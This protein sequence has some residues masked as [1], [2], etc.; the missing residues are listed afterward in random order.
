MALN[1]R[2]DS[3]DTLCTYKCLKY[4]HVGTTTFMHILSHMCLSFLFRLSGFPGLAQPNST[5][6]DNIGSKHWQEKSLHIHEYSKLKKKKQKQ[7]N[8]IQNSI[9]KTFRLQIDVKMPL[10]MLCKYT[11]ILPLSVLCWE[12]RETFG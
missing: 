2:F 1:T 5:E 9:W 3:V 10:K 6:D 7:I 8:R 11:I 4:K 12:V